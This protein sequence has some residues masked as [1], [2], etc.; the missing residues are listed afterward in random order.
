MREHTGLGGHIQR[1][2]DAAAH[3]QVEHWLAQ[4]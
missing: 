3:Q 4:V 2:P 1:Q